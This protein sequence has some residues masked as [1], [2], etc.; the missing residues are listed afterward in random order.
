MKNEQLVKQ[1]HEFRRIRF[2]NNSANCS[3]K[4]SIRVLFCAIEDYHKDNNGFLLL[5]DCCGM[6]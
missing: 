1:I 2:V 4:N 3:K 6:P 5:A